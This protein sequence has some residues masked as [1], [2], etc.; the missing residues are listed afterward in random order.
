[1]NSITR[2]RI[3]EVIT[4]KLDVVFSTG[5]RTSLADAIEL[6]VLEFEKV[7]GIKPL[8]EVIFEGCNDTDEVLMEWSKILNDYAKVS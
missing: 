2:L 4:R 3:E 7:E 8:L 5:D 1:M 6:A